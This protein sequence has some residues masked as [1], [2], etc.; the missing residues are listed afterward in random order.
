MLVPTISIAQGLRSRRPGRTCVRSRAAALVAVGLALAVFLGGAHSA[1]AD[2]VHDLSHALVHGKRATTRISAAESLIRLRD[3]RSLKSLVR[4]L[5]DPN[6]RVR[7]LAASA[8]GRLG[9]V[10]AL[11]A[12]EGARRDTSITVRRNAIAAIE[13]IRARQD[14]A[15]R[16]LA[17]VDIAPRHAA[18][19]AGSPLVTPEADEE[20]PAPQRLY[21]MLKSAID[22]SSGAGPKARLA[23]A[24]HMRSLM[25]D[26]LEQTRNVTLIPSRAR[27]LTVDPYAIDLTMVK[28]SRVE[29]ESNIE[30]ECEIR[31]AIST[32]QGK[33]LSFLTGGA[34]V[35]VPRATFREQ[36]L[37]Q[38]R[39]EALE[40]A[41]RSVHR[42]LIEHL[43]K[44]P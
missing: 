41:V 15:A 2:R 43:A 20:I 14:E 19:I 8:L 26:H 18:A 11:P 44:L 39:R 17:A 34:K 31:V 38:L 33:M 40:G 1:R 30:V 22:K 3:P 29:R 28:L 25:A 12:L 35:Q 23:R 5:R 36:F 10:D 37:P 7:A 16:K 32:P 27:A 9:V 4:A 13:S 24:S 42:D 6:H 21:V